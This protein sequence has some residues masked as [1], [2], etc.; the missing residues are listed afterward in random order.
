L[1]IFNYKFYFIFI[2]SR[3]NSWSIWNKFCIIW[4]YIRRQY[5]YIWDLYHTKWYFFEYLNSLGTHTFDLSLYSQ[6]SNY[7]FVTCFERTNVLIHEG[8]FFMSLI[9]RLSTSI[10]H[11][12][13]MKS[14][15][16][17]RV[18]E[19]YV[20]TIFIYIYIY[21]YICFYEIN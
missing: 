19:L 13:N 20:L 17:L 16:I 2:L 9:S 11:D 14:V 4:L 21:I 1:L 15:R 12:N 8:Q 5:V 3:E 7:S 18:T 10:L 6:P